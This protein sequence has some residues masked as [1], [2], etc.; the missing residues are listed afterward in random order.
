MAVLLGAAAWGKRP[1]SSGVPAST[2]LE[3]AP[4][5]LATLP[6]GRKILQLQPW[7]RKLFP[8]LRVV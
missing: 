3:H 8:A 4:I 7:I 2:E 6:L 5:K 1:T